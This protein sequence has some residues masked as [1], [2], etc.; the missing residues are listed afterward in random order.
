MVTHCARNAE[1][2]F[3][4]DIFNDRSIVQQAEH[5]YDMREVDKLRKE[6]LRGLLR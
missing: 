4:S 1:S 2:R 6:K 3:D 5:P